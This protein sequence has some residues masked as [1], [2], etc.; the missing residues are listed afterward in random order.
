MYNSTVIKIIFLDFD[1][2]LYSH[3]SNQIPASFYEAHD[4][5]KSKGILM[6]LCTGRSRYELDH[7]FDLSKLDLSYFIYN[8]G[9]LITDKDGNIIYS[10]PISGIDKDNAIKLFN[11][12]RISMT[13]GTFDDFYTNIINENTIR[14][15]ETISSP[16]P[17]VK[18][19][20]NEDFYIVSLMSDDD[21][22]IEKLQHIYFPNCHLERW[23]NN[24]YDVT[25]NGIDKAQGIYQII[26]K[27][28]ISQDEVMAF[29]DGENDIAM[30]K[31]AKIGVAMGNSNEKVKQSADYITDDIDNKGIYNALK[32]FKII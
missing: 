7:Y 1:G 13:I 6:C 9:Q 14:T 2:T 19:Y 24:S 22:D 17:E 4:I 8:N 18:E 28:N 3:A 25:I 16:L 30:L 31:Y 23:E 27:L 26:K 20:H 12:K 5:L 15:C 10:C 11:E 21:E 32:Y 29:G